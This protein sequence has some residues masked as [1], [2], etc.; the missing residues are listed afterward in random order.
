[1]MQS[2]QNSFFQIQSWLPLSYYLKP[3]TSWHGLKELKSRQSMRSNSWH[4]WEVTQHWHCMCPHS[5]P[6]PHEVTISFIEKTNLCLH[7]QLSKKWGLW[8]SKVLHR[9]VI[10]HFWIS[11]MHFL[12]W[13]TLVDLALSC[14]DCILWL[15]LEINVMLTK[16]LFS[17]QLF[18]LFCLFLGLETI[19]VAAF[20]RCK[21]IY[22]KWPG[23]RNIPLTI[24]VNFQCSTF[25][26]PFRTI[27]PC[28]NYSTYVVRDFISFFCEQKVVI[29]SMWRTSL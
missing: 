26:K 5:P 7:V 29:Q 2:L 12:L 28:L 1:M 4:G 16:L 21:H 24:S 15:L 14:L 8:I 22:S 25:K 17:I 6:L 19:F 3:V 20:P 23:K 13:S 9:F 11:L 27:F 18:F 10:C